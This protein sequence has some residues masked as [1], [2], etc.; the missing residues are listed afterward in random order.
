MSLPFTVRTS[1]LECAQASHK[2][3]QR[4]LDLSMM[5]SPETSGWLGALDKLTSRQAIHVLNP[6]HESIFIARFD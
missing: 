6:R 1:H 2:E 3:R 4:D 5:Q